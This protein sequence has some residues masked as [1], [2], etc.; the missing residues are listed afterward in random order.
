MYSQPRF[1]LIGMALLIA[2]ALQAPSSGAQDIEM[3]NIPSGT[4]LMGDSV[5]GHSNEQPEHNVTISPGF[6]IGTFE[7]T[8][9]QFITDLNYALQ[10]PPVGWEIKGD[11]NGAAYTG[12]AVYVAGHKAIEVDD[13]NGWCQIVY[14]DATTSFGLRTH[15]SGKSMAD[16]PVVTVTWY[17]AVAFCNWES[18]RK[19]LTPAYV[20]SSNPSSALAGPAALS[21]SGLTANPSTAELSCNRSTATGYRLPTESEWEMSASYDS[22]FP[23]PGYKWQFGFMDLVIDYARANYSRGLSYSDPEDLTTAPFT[24]SKGFFNGAN[25][26]KW[27][28]TTVDSKSPFFCYDMSGNVAEWCQDAYFDDYIGAPG[29]GGARE[30]STGVPRVIRGGS[31]ADSEDAVRSAARSSLAPDYGGVTTCTVGFRIARTSVPPPGVPQLDSL[32]PV[33]T[34]KSYVLAGVNVTITG[35]HF[36][37]IDAENV[38]TLDAGA[39]LTTTTAFGANPEGTQVQFRVP[40][41]ILP[42]DDSAYPLTVLVRLVVNNVNSVNYLTFQ[43]YPDSGGIEPTTGTLPMVPVPAGQFQMGDPWNEGNTNERPL[44]TVT[45]A[46]YYLMGKFEI[47]NAQYAN[48]LNWALNNNW[49]LATVSEDITNAN[50]TPYSGGS[51]YIHG[52]LKAVDLSDPTCEIEYNS[53]TALFSSKTRINDIGVP[54]STAD[55][56][57]VMVSWYG[58]VAFCNWQSRI[59]EINP[60][61]DMTALIPTFIP[62]PLARLASPAGGEPVFSDSQYARLSQQ[63]SSAGG[64]RLPAESEWE[65]AAAYDP[66]HDNPL[67]GQHFRYGFASDTIT[68]SRANYR[69]AFTDTFNNPVGFS[70]DDYPFSAHIGFFN[71]SNSGVH[72]NTADSKSYYGCYDMSGNAAEWCQDWYHDSYTSAPI[73]GSAWENHDPSATFRILRG[74]SWYD[75]D[76]K[77]RTASREKSGPTIVWNTIGF[78]VARSGSGLYPELTPTPTIIPSMTPTPSNTPTPGPTL[79]PTPV[80]TPE[81]SVQGWHSYQ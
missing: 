73:D 21:S 75:D 22:S 11:A 54:V 47:T 30:G 57:V 50:G 77:L 18:L 38:V 81:A 40:Q 71:G 8:N 28:L 55:H 61:Y 25:V 20:L 58:A 12:G 46:N 24:N 60:V 15:P 3:S 63:Y 80:I 68:F 17:G 32:T 34:R 26:T 65:R 10:N 41:S 29:G 59:E 67:S 44:H 1:L 48:A 69:D 52:V 31:W 35:S 4:F 56:P 74:G 9:Q 49:Q 2:I 76:D 51:V 64:Y 79:T 66:N 53:S 13:P 42:A 16:H 33:G 37:A 43:I 62:A 5:S 19:G 72:T 14:S 45:F 70:I 39:G 27:G 23:D 78:R 7:I 6:E 36:S